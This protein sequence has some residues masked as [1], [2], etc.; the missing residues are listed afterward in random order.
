[1]EKVICDVCGTAYPETAAQC[2]VC[3]CANS[4]SGQ[5]AAGNTVEVEEETTPTT[6]KGGRF[7]KTNV[8]KR[9]KAAQVTP[10]PEDIASPE[11]NYDEPDDEDDY[12]DY[13]EDD[14]DDEPSS[15]RG[16]IIVVVLLLLAIIA[17][18]SY[19][20]IKHF[21]IFDKD[22][23]S[24]DPIVTTAPTEDPAPDDIPDPSDP[25]DPA[26]P[27]DPIDPGTRIPCTG[28][29]VTTNLTLLEKGGS[30][31]LSFSIDPIDTTDTIKFKS[32]NPAVATVDATGRVTAV[33]KGEA[34]I[35]ITCGSV[36]KTCKIVCDFEEVPVVPEKN[37]SLKLNN[38]KPSYPTG[39]NSCEASFKTGASFTLKIVDDDGVAVDVV[40]T[41]SKPENVVITGNTIKIYKPGSVTISATH[42]GITYS[43]LARVTGDAI[44]IP[45]E[46]PDD[47][48]KPDDPVD[49]VATF[50]IRIN[51]AKPYYPIGDFSC[52][53]SFKVGNSFRL[54]LVND[55]DAKMNVTWTASKDGYVT[56]EGER[57]TC[58]QAIKGYV[59]LTC[60]Y[61]GQTYTCLVRISE[62]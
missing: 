40:W 52:E 42:N 21:G 45:T 48:E 41:A 10:V 43:C 35:T 5:T 50:F 44:D 9:L 3:G 61:E 20:V 31:S 17:V 51:G 30:A 27:T 56:I 2:P 46:N 14:V 37:Y 47:P 7:S 8:R 6:G 62:P 60:E 53:A 25:T 33:G 59:T 22:P 13:D 26:D 36:T 57:I 16:L 54:N 28:I 39:E 49:P 29:E 12:D 55:L 11:V 18:S 15:N 19:I 58:V 32:S 34:T 23:G 38:M 24:T 1:M 4:E